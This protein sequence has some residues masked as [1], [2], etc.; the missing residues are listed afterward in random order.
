MAHRVLEQVGDDLVDTFGI[1]VG[2]EIGGVDLDRHVDPGRVQALFPHRV[3][4]QGL[5]T[6]RGALERHRA[7]LE[8]GQVEQLLDQAAEAFDLPEHGVE[9]LGVGFGNAVDEVLEDSLQRGDGR[10]E[11]VRHVGDEV[12]PHPVGF[13]QIGG[14]PVER[15]CELTDLVAR[16]RVHAAL[17]VA[18]GHLGRGGHHL[19]Q[20]RC[21]APREEP[22]HGHRDRGGEDARG[23]RPQLDLQPDPEHEDGD[24]DRCR[25]DEAQLELDR[26]DVVERDGR[27]G[28]D[29]SRVV[30]SGGVTDAVHGAHDVVAELAAERAHVRVD[31]AR[32]GA[33]VIAPH[34]REQLLAGE[35]PRGSLGTGTRAGRTRWG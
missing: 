8:P 19:A 26:R 20:R 12:A 14:H 31:R 24:R 3:R 10:A 6:E 27:D 25:D 4:E 32:A 34:L 13:G 22:D 15:P 33:V 9:G 1:A 23:R 2:G 17:V 21:H 35:D 29:G 28:R 18:L 30:F 16:R 7:G 5:D 11:L